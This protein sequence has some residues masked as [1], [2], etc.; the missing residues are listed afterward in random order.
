MKT[1]LLILVVIL[2]S[3]SALAFDWGAIGNRFKDAGQ[4]IAEN[5]KKAFEPKAEAAATI[6][7]EVAEK[8]AEASDKIVPEEAPAEIAPAAP[9][10]L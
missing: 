2:C 3:Q 7:A 9:N 5:V 8:I 10:D 4:K 1:K 6:A